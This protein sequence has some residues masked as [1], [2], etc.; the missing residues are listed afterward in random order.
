[1]Q[2]K[3]VALAFAFLLGISI[4]TL[5]QAA[6]GYVTGNVNLRSGPGTQYGQI[7]T[8]PA[9]SGVTVRGC[10]TGYSWCD[11]SFAGRR[12]WVSSNYLQVV[13]QNQRRPL[14]FVGPRIR[15]PIISHHRPRP[16][17]WKPNRPRP[18]HNGHRPRPP[19][20]QPR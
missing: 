4:P 11:V 16:P 3:T 12:G 7:T 20:P 18:P 1:M 13:Y 5:A 17:Q 2:V 9:G 14:I 6:G 19:R 15:L 8:I 10:L